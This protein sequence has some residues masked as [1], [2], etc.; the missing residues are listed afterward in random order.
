MEEIKNRMKQWQKE[1]KLPKMIF[2]FLIL[3]FIVTGIIGICV[4]HNKNNR[5]ERQL[6][7]GDQYLADMDY[8]RAIAAYEEAL[9]L[10]DKCVEAYTGIAEAYIQLGDLDMAIEYLELGMERTGSEELGIRLGEVRAIKEQLELAEQ[11]E[12]TEG[13]EDSEGQEEETPESEV[14]ET[15][16]ESEAPEEEVAAVKPVKKPEPQPEPE[17]EPELEPSQ[18]VVEPAPY[19]PQPQPYI[20]QPEPQPI[21]TPK[22]EPTPEPEVP[23]LPPRGTNIRPI[24]MN[25]YLVS[26]G[27]DIHSMST[28]GECTIPGAVIKAELCEKNDESAEPVL[29]GS[30]NGEK[31]NFASN[32]D[33]DYQY[34]RITYE[35]PDGNYFVNAYDSTETVTLYKYDESMDM[36]SG[37]IV[38]CLYEDYGDGNSWQDNH[39]QYEDEILVTCPATDGRLKIQPS[40]Y[41][42]K[43][44]DI[45][46][47]S[48]L[49]VLYEDTGGIE[50]DISQQPLLYIYIADL[51]SDSCMEYVSG[52]EYRAVK[53]GST[54]IVA[55]YQGRSVRI[56]LT[57]VAN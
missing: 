26:Y 51:Y 50:E 57:V 12:E 40:G 56:P 2:V 21:P 8:E 33:S 3:L 52:T 18:T 46:D 22:P 23:G 9:R 38:K 29:L 53:E 36:Y 42:I 34:I 14:T 39:S 45:V 27:S 47:L 31:L 6:A 20:P 10:D 32:G 7:L 11:E 17:P 30:T 48:T 5:L 4:Y 43:T 16:E 49:T 1:K 55:F 37:M 54:Y 25:F 13:E 24:E 44:G 15:E 28:Y 41:T 19:I 35:L